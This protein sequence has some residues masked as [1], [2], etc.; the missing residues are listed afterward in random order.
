MKMN[1][2]C[3]DKEF[4]IMEKVSNVITSKQE[5]D[6]DSVFDEYGAAELQS[7]NETTVLLLKKSPGRNI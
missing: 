5:K 6:C 1:V 7:I 3:S 4:A 2:S